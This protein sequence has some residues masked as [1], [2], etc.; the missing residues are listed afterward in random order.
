MLYAVPPTAAPA[1]ASAAIVV[2][3]IA[4]DI[5][6]SV[7]Y[8]LTLRSAC[9]ISRTFDPYLPASASRSFPAGIGLL[10][11]TPRARC[12]RP[13]WLFLKAPRAQR[14]TTFFA[15]LAILIPP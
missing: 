7:A 15:P 4:P 1:P 9:A 12:R 3:E 6:P 8:L 13:L 10:G 14:S 5:T 11:S 2:S